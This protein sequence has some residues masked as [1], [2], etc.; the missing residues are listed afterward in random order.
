MIHNALSLRNLYLR[1]IITRNTISKIYSR[2]TQYYNSILKI[3]SMIRTLI[4]QEYGRYS[5]FLLIH[6]LFLR[7]V[8]Q[9]KYESFK[10]FGQYLCR[11]R[12]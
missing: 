4:N 9:S 2:S 12:K 8:Y 1:D 11:Y 3:R 5:P 7:H 10:V 6:S